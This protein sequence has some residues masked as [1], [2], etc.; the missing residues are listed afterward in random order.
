MCYKKLLKQSFYYANIGLIAML[1]DFAVLYF[2]VEFL[3][4]N[5]L[6]AVVLAFFVAVIFNFIAQ[7]K[8][9]FKDQNKNHAFQITS[10]FL[11]GIVGMGMNVGII[12]V[13]VEYLG[14]WYMFGKV[15]A[16]GVA[17]VW[18]F[19]ANKFITFRFA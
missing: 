19:L 8:F 12:Y 6:I 7:K 1:I 15:F 11:I 3:Y 9:T 5:Y 17:F 10:F 2:L 4:V 14:L 16:T 18:N 13:C